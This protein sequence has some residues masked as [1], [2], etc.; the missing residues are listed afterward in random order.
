MDLTFREYLDSKKQL[1]KA[2]EQTPVAVKE[3]EIRKYCSIA[4]GE[5]K[6][7]AMNVALKP[8]QTIIVEWR[9]DNINDPTIISIKFKGVQA[10]DEQY[11]TFWT[12]S[13]MKKWLG[14]HTKG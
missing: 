2:I 3:Y 5:T 8:K 11:Q 14:R 13:K 6:E 1:R 9:Y 7:D 4:L 10:L 12:S